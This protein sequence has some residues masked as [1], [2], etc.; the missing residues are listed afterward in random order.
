MKKSKDNQKI[1]KIKSQS[2]EDLAIKKKVK[3]LLRKVS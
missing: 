2:K 3:I 1:E